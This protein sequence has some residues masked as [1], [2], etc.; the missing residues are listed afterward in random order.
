[1]IILRYILSI[2]YY[3]A[4]GI[5]L[6]IMHPLQW[7][8]LH[9]FGYKGH[10]MVVNIMNYTLVQA[11][12]II[13]VT[14]VFEN[15]YDLPIDRP[16]VF[17][18]N[19]QSL[20][21]IS[22]MASHFRKHHVKFVSKKELGKG[23]P[24]ISYNLNHGGSVLIDRKDRKQALLALREFAQY[25]ENNNRSTVIYP[26]GTRS[27]DG[28]PKRFSKNGLQMILK[29]APSALIVPVTINNSW[30]V[31][32]DGPFPLNLGIAI[33]FTT[34]KPIENGSSDFDDIFDRVENSIK[35]AVV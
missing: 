18:S 12:K 17:V 14:T 15:K 16:I 20:Y 31:V 34:H 3:L 35:E 21:D 32:K 29:Y 19:H 24:S 4:F 22:A 6:L 23:I 5:T 25:L 28:K 10:N 2:L 9:L 7:L 8:G 27:R 26:E 13:G 1:M 33:R 11:L 30:K